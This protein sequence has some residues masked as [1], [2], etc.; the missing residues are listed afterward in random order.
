ME[1]DRIL[2]VSP[3]AGARFSYHREQAAG[4]RQ[5]RPTAEEVIALEPDLIVR[6]YGGGPHAADFFERAGIPVHQ[7]GFGADLAGVRQLVVEMA[8]ALGVPGRGAELAARLDTVS[9]PEGRGTALYLT[10]GGV[11]AGP[12]TL[13]HELLAA[14]GYRNFQSSPGFREIPLE[15]LAYERPDL[16]VAAFYEDAVAHGGSWSSARHPLVRRLVAEGP[17]VFL[18]GAWVGCGGWFLADAIEA[19]AEGP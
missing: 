5:V 16:T 11:T 12:G 7:I 15:R 2:A 8:A 10:P 13:I 1:P 19:L 9:A 18:E 14:A 3:D 6:S 4:I 17:V